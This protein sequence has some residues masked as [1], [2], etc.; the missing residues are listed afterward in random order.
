MLNL[1]AI[2]PAFLAA[3]AVALVPII[4]HLV[5]RRR[6]Q[7]V[8]FGSVR[9]LRKMS[10]RVVRRHRL[11]ELILILLRVAALLLVALGFAR[12]F[13][14]AAG[15][16]AFA[17]GASAE[18]AVLVLV[19]NSYS[20]TRGDRLRR[21][22]DEARKVVEAAGPLTRVA[23]A[24]FAGAIAETADFDAPRREA[25]RRIDSIQPSYRP[26]RLG[27]VLQRAGEL[28][29]G[30]GE[31]LR[32][33]VLISDFQQSSWDQG[34]DDRLPPGVDLET[35]PVA[36]AAEA[37]NVFVDG[38]QA[39]SL[40]VAGGFREPISARIANRTDQTIPDAAVTLTV[41]G[42]AVE[43]RQ[44]TIQP[45][46]DALVRFPLT[47]TAAGEVTG[48]IAIK[49]D[50]A[51]PADNQG[52]FAVQVAPKARVLLVNGD[53]DPSRVRNDGFF[54]RTALAPT[55]PGRPSPFEVREVTP[56]RLT[57][58]D[59]R[60]VEAV[61]LANVDTIPAPA[62]E[63]LTEFLYAG[64]GVALLPGGRTDPDR[65]NKTFRSGAEPIAPCQLWKPALADGDDPVIITWTDRRH[66]IFRL[67]A[68]P[69][70][71]DM[72]VAEFRQY[73]QVRDSQAA[74]VLA[75]FS[76]GHP[77]LLEM[78]CSRGTGAG[79]TGRSVLFTSPVDL[80]WNDLCLKGVF[81]PFV[82]QL[83]LR[84]C[85]ERSGGWSR[86]LI[87]GDEAVIPLGSQAKDV[88]VL[89]PDGKEAEAG[90]PEDGRVRFTPAAPGLYQIQYQGGQARFAANLA[91][92]EADLTEMDVKVLISAVRSNTAT[93]RSLGGATVLSARTAEERVEQSQR[94]W[95]YLIAA[96]LAL[97]AVEMILGA[98]A[99][100]A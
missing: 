20:M 98:R 13:F 55:T 77:A 24:E 86:D 61:V 6:R 45:R 43:T 19:D 83:S 21:A 79:A 93:A 81:V 78:L 14:Y 2:N 15:D 95:V 9:F 27:M 65:F 74:Q 29:A 23:V 57:G 92:G 73:F 40:A 38:V 82:H 84:L 5:T 22:R 64:G 70:H 4:L 90:V 41:D 66:D 56:D 91:P 87:V 96:A 69:R 7:R 59:I 1:H 75:R 39:P 49:F 71:G 97:L 48:T 16:R 52:W 99:A 25:L 58:E 54:L 11:T 28:M 12:L 62:V 26:T 100:A 51:M 85:A 47:F 36:E 35:R 3:S 8:V 89:G 63:A 37:A 42:K 67:F 50:D 60:G 17:G 32:R 68:G 30:R 53:P 33:I 76:N 94:I 46:S 34:R 18:G 10:Q 72:A 88:R 44:V 31:P 80:E